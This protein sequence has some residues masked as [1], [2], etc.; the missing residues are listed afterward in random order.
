MITEE[1]KNLLESKVV[2]IGTKSEFPNVTPVLY[3]KVIDDKVIITN[4]Y[5]GETIENI[6]ADNS[7]CL[8]V[9]DATVGKEFGYKLFG[10][11][12]YH[13]EGKWLDFVKGLKENRDLSPKGA[14]IFTPKSIKKI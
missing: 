7:V 11:A 4:N 6:N 3:C 10:K 2:A 1:I 8:A 12:E 9:W 5:M 14:I 13:K